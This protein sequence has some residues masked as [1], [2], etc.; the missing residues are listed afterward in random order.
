MVEARGTTLSRGN[1]FA[2]A[3]AKLRGSP[4]RPFPSD[5]AVKTGFQKGRYPDV[6]IDCG[7]G[8][9]SVFTIVDSAEAALS[10][11]TEAA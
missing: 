8:L 9:D 6:T 11:E 2:S 10:E 5:M 1:L 7:P 4:C 3:L